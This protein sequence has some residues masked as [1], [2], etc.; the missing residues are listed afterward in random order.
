MAA[1]AIFLSALFYMYEKFVLHVT[2]FTG[3]SMRIKG[4]CDVIFA[5]LILLPM[6]LSA[7]VVFFA[8]NI[9]HPGMTPTT[10]SG[11]LRYPFLAV[12]FWLIMKFSAWARTKVRRQTSP[13]SQKS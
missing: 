5:L 12:E 8:E 2:D 3:I 4:F 13:R 9:F 1:K 7:L 6:T 11:I 10:E